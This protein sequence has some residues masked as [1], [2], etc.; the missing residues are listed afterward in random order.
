MTRLMFA[1]RLFRRDWR[2]GEIRLLTLALVLAVTAVT[3]V[4]FFTNRVERAMELQAA[5]LLAADLVIRSSNPVPDQFHSKAHSLGLKTARIL[6]FPSVI[7]QGDT[8]RL[9]QVK[10]VSPE[11]PLRGELRVRRA[12]TAAE[13]L[14]T[15]PPSGDAIWIEPRLAAELGLATG[16]TLELGEKR[17]DVTRIISRDTGEGGNL[18]RLGARVLLGLDAI[19]ATGLV[20]PASRVRHSLLVAGEPHAVETYRTWAGRS[21]SP[22]LRLEHMSNARPELRKALDRGRRFLQ[23][24]ALAAVL[25]AG[26]A[27]ALATRRFVQKQSDSSAI[28]RCL[29]ASSGF[30][31]QVLVLRMGLIGLLSTAVGSLFGYLA[32]FTIAGL[33]G[34]LFIT[35]LPP[36]SLS[37]VLIGFGTGLITLSGFTLAPLSRLGNV[38]P[39]RVLRRELG[40]APLSFWLSGGAAFIAMSLLM[41]WQA[42]EIK[43]AAAVILGTLGGVVLL[44]GGGQL[45]IRLLNPLR[46]RTGAIWRQG[47]GGLARNPGM[48][49]IQ[50]AGFGLGILA[51]LLLAI[52]RLD[53]LSA[54]ERTIPEQTPNQFLI[55]IQP[56]EVEQ[57]QRFL[58][59]SGVISGG[60]YPMLRARLVKINRK[61]AT[62]DSYTNE[63]AQRLL[64]RE[65]NLS[66]AGALQQ[67]NEV[68]AGSWW[69]P[70]EY[71][72]TRFSVEKGLADTLGIR[73]NDTLSFDLAGVEIEAR[74]TSLRSVQWDSFQ[75][76]FFVIG[77]PGLLRD[78]PAM[79]ITSFY[80]PPG[81]E[82]LLAKLVQAFPSVTVIDVSAVMGHVREI[83]NRGSMAVEYVFLFTLGAGLL[84]LYAGIQASRET[85]RQES[86]ILRT[87]GLQKGRLFLSVGIE[88]LVMGALA[89]FLASLAATLTGWYLSTELF[90]LAYR[91]N[92]DIWL[93]GILGGAVGIGAAGMLATYPLVVQPPL[94][95][96]R[97]G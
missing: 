51:L 5:E 10:A 76:N 14:A 27:I 1:L 47:L 3:A 62:P 92:P 38:P 63:R 22:G 93:Y 7:V 30:I 81:E 18:F 65:F 89:G 21:L 49:S 35:D 91:W 77:T 4:G 13:E 94:H 55:N 24:A 60:I 31:R 12:T 64:S 84:V 71:E 15:A 17:F 88:F 79:Y 68:V 59:E 19:E 45:L 29:G 83:I 46:F 28:M 70:P 85:R 26:A 8:T 52:V 72:Q 57:L 43:L 25:V 74:V 69:Q 97:R 36:P 95:V 16:K 32:Q 23:L 40:A 87:L 54:W 80:L 2:S 90:D 48:T 73:L 44:I 96:L 53:L 50:M 75:P 20:T 33:V 58:Q 6:T 11:Y 78:Y 39:L 37:P 66:W 41:I 61:P 9:V 56:Q 86:A 82:K 67:G 34:E 42:G